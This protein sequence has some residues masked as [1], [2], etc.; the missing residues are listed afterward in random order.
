MQSLAAAIGMPTVYIMPKCLGEM[1]TYV[2]S[3]KQ[4]GDQLKEPFFMM[5]IG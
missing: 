1:M 2:A 4:V 5:I 3:V